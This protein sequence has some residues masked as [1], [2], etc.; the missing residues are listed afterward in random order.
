MK[1]FAAISFASLILV[2]SGL[3]QTMLH[4]CPQKGIVFTKQACAMHAQQPTK[5]CCKKK[6][7]TMHA[8]HSCCSEAYFFALSPKFGNID[9]F[10]VDGPYIHYV[11]TMHLPIA[12]SFDR[13]QK[14]AAYTCLRPPPEVSAFL[15]N[16]CCWIV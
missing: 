8:K 11:P 2:S 12:N 7:V 13:T 5:E 16:V 14:T 1:R 4:I 3:V 9:A 6:H 15:S 10:Q